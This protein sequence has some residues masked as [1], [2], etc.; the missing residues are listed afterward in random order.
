MTQNQAESALLFDEITFTLDQIARACRRN[1]E[2]VVER[3]ESELL[4][5]TRDDSAVWLFTSMDL[6]RARRLAS[7]ESS[8]ETN[9]D[10]AALIVD[11]IEE[12]N[13]LRQKLRLAGLG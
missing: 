8:F 11:L 3:V 12:N 9:Q 4:C 1:P 10:A 7:I 5:A 13:R 6:I 2:W